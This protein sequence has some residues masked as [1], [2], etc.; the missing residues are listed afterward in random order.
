MLVLAATAYLA[1]RLLLT[2]APLPLAVAI[3]LLLAALLNPVNR[4]L[5]RLRVPNALAA[6]AAC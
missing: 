1:G 6:L 5:R 2:V 3:S 4:L